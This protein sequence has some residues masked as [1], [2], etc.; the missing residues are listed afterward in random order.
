[1]P[2]AVLGN[3]NSMENK[4]EKGSFF[5][6]LEMMGVGGRSTRKTS[7]KISSGEKC[8]EENTMDSDR[9]SNMD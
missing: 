4:M 5:C 1:M 3:E 6:L 9:D 2:E 8:Y 7:K